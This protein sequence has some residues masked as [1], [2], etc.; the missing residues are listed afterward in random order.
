M[1]TNLYVDGF[2]LYYRAVQEKPHLKWLD[3]R[4]LAQVLFPGDAIQSIHYFTSPLIDR[5]GEDEP[6]ERQKQ[7]RQ[8]VYLEALRTIP[9]LTIHLGTFQPQRN[10]RRLVSQ[11]S[12]KVLVHD[13]SEKKSDVNLAT[14]LVLDGCK[15]TYEQ[16]AILSEDSDFV[17]AIRSVRNEL[18]LPVTL[19]NPDARKADQPNELRDVAA[20]VIRMRER[21]LEQSQLPDV[22]YDSNGRAV[23]KPP[24]WN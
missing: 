14:R 21:H 20:R 1:L 12:D 22:V 11:P 18:G 10:M 2:N 24:E 19:V 8:L 23:Q 7:R 16:A 9:G 4:K 6:K 17:E 3:L 5:P 13:V 15:G